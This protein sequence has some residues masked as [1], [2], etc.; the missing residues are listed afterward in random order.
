MSAYV[1]EYEHRFPKLTNLMS[2]FNLSWKHLFDWEATEPTFESVVRHYKATHSATEIKQAMHEL[3][4][5]LALP[6]GEEE[7]R[8]ATEQMNA[9]YYP[10]G[11]GQT[12]YQWLGEVLTILKEPQHKARAMRI[13]G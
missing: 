6:L 13:I 5:L 10:P 9:A 4:Q 12:Y 7:L 1:S 3:E 11:T 8:D 2:Y